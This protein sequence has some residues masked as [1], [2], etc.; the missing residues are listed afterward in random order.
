[1]TSGN[2]LDFKELLE[3]RQAWYLI[4][5]EVK[6]KQCK[7]ILSLFFIQLYEFIQTHKTED[8]HKTKK[9][10]HRLSLYLD[11]FAQ[12]TI[13]DFPMI[14]TTLRRYGVSQSLL[15]QDMRQLYK[16]G[17]DGASAIFNGSCATKIIFPGMSLELAEK[18]SR[19]FGRTSISLDP[20][21]VLKLSDRELMTAQE[22]IQLP[23][24]KALFLYRNERPHIMMMRPYF[25]QL[26][27]R[28]KAKIK[29]VKRKRNEVA[30]P[31]LLPLNLNQ[32]SHG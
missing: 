31:E 29:P 10:K 7:S 32:M 24:G 1:L 4:V 20:S 28:R 8:D 17:V 23:K 18:L 13:P 22:L 3:K 6:L 9:P 15:I 2:D 27:L 26:R 5:P 14:A 16:Y 30:P 11:E 19:S 12:L 25:K 21:D